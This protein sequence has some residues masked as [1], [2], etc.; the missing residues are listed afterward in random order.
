MLCFT[1][2]SFV[3]IFTSNLYTSKAEAELFFN[4]GS[5]AYIFIA[6][7][8]LWFVAIFTEKKKL[9]KNHFFFPVIFAVSAL[10]IY[11]H[12]TG[13]QMLSGVIKQPYG[14]AYT[15]ADSIWVYL[16]YFYFTII[17]TTSFYF[18]FDFGRKQKNSAKRKQAKLILIAAFFAATLGGIVHFILPELGIYKIPAMGNIVMFAWVLVLIYTVVKYEFLNITPASAAENIISMMTDSLILLDSSGKISAA[19]EASLNLV[20][21]EKEEL[22]GKDFSVL[23]STHSIGKLN[24]ADKEFVRLIEDG[25]TEDLKLTYIAKDGKKRIPILFSASAMRDKAGNLQGFVIVARDITGIKKTEEELRGLNEQLKENERAVLNVLSDLEK[26][27][28]ELKSSQEQLVQS[29]KMASIG[30]LVSDMAHEVNNPLMIISGRAQLSLMDAKGDKELEGSLG[31]IMDQCARAKDV[32]QRLLTFSKPSKGELKEA[33]VNDSVEFV[34]KLIEHQFS[35]T[36]VK[37][38]KDYTP[39]DLK[40]NID[41]KQMHEVFMNLLK[42]AQDAMPEGGTITITTSKEVSNA[43]IDF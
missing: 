28:E 5:F 7:V 21:Y 16:F 13:P 32:I 29:S 37:I 33:G 24:I 18:L 42:N 22:I 15:W 4:I 30:R 9:L 1:V 35:L 20:G 27:H 12:I 23:F 40:I 43:R 14:W 25:D 31:I 26:S 3:L 41:E 8:F 36:K 38:V 10:F 2:W 34:V 11:K 17:V 19:N 6:G 39:E